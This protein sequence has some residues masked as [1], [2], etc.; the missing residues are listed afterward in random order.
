MSLILRDVNYLDLSI[1][2]FINLLAHRSLVLDETIV[3]V[4]NNN[5]L[6]GALVFAVIWYLWFQHKDDRNKHE[7][8]LAGVG[9]SFIGLTVAKVFTWLIVRPRPFNEPSV[10]IRIPYGI[11][12]ANWEGLNSFPSDHGVLFFALATGIF[13]ASR[14]AGWL[15]FIY[16]SAFICLPRI[17]LGIHYPT[18]VLAGAAIGLSTGWLVHLPA[19]RRPFTY[20]ALRWLDARPGQ[21]YACSFLLTYLICELFDPLI[22]VASFIR[23]GYLR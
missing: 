9:A 1:L 4:C 5:F 8:L 2:H 10:A 18:D 11:E 22:S 17:Y 6:K 7:Y 12:V 13:F 20:W 21:F 19:I 3:L 16:I 15:M 14:R 23:H